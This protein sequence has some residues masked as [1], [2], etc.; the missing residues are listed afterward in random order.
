MEQSQE[1]YQTRM[2]SSLQCLSSSVLVQAC[3]LLLV[4]C[5]CQPPLV[6]ILYPPLESPQS[7]DHGP[8]KV[9]PLSSSNFSLGWQRR[10]CLQ[11]VLILIDWW[12]IQSLDGLGCQFGPWYQPMHHEPHLD[13][14]AQDVR[15]TSVSPQARSYPTLSWSCSTSMRSNDSWPCM[16]PWKTWSWEARWVK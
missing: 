2:G 14:E 5:T 4:Q 10:Y 9:A 12:M 6:A 8:L 11:T 16:D 13:S 7:K 1:I 15:C 3:L